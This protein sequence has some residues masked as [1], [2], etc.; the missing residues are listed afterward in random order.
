ML[1]EVLLLLLL[2]ILRLPNYSHK[3]INGWKIWLFCNCRNIWFQTR[4][5]GVP[6]VI[7]LNLR[8]LFKSLIEC[9]IKIFFWDTFLSLKSLILIIDL[10]QVINS[11]FFS[12]LLSLKS[13]APFSS[14]VVFRASWGG[15]SVESLICVRSEM[16]SWAGTIYFMKGSVRSIYIITRMN[17]WELSIPVWRE[18]GTI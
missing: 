18:K 8:L 12:G 5:E 11:L 17:R 13:R 14:F 3:L 16:I 7:C 2:V 4:C 10:L 9:R 15:W 6:V 1:L